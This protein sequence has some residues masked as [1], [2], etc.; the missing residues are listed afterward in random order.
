MAYET[1]S[2]KK[3]M[4]FLGFIDEMGYLCTREITYD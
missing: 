3:E 1:K 4:F 2:N